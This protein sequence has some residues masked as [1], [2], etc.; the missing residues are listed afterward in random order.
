MSNRHEIKVTIVNRLGLHARPA[1]SFVDTANLYTSEVR[2]MRDDTEVDGKSIMQMM[3]LAAGQGT[4]LVIVT[5][6]PDAQAAA[7]ALKALVDG[8]FEEE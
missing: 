8:G 2:V 5:E 3:M 4:E 7:A 1:M 6:G